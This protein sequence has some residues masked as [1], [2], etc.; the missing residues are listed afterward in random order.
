M[1]LRT[2]IKGKVME[3]RIVTDSLKN[4]PGL[5]QTELLRTKGGQELQLG[6]ATSVNKGSTAPESTLLGNK[7]AIGVIVV[8]SF[9]I[10]HDL[11]QRNANE[12]TPAATCG[13]SCIC[14]PPPSPNCQ[15]KNC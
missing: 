7:Q 13:A 15:S 14:P 9:Q 8:E 3:V 4:V 12:S 11:S 6:I 10:T 5:Q 2:E 1:P